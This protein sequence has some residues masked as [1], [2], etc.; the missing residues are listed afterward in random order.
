MAMTQP[1]TAS[2]V[3]MGVITISN[4]GYVYADNERG[5]D[6]GNHY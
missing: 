3:R 1:P 5:D 2:V 4:G 6:G